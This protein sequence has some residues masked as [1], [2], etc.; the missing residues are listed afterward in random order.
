MMRLLILLALTTA[1][2]QARNSWSWGPDDSSGAGSATT[3]GRSGASVARSSDR[4]GRTSTPS[5]AA[6]FHPSSSAG[7]LAVV[8]P[9]SA[10]AFTAETAAPQ[11]ALLSAAVSAA[12]LVTGEHQR[13]ETRTARKIEGAS[14]GL[15]EG[16]LF[17]IKDK[18]CEVGL[19]FDC[20][21]GY[22]G[23]LSHHDISYVQPVQ[24]VPVGGPIA[25]VP[26]H[27][28][29]G[30][31]HKGYGVPPP[32]YGPPPPIYSPPVYAPPQPIYA[33]PQPSYG[34]P[35]PVYG[36]HKSSYSESVYHEGS[37]LVNHVHT[38][39]HLYDGP[40]VYGKDNHYSGTQT[41]S[42]SSS[43]SFTSFDSLEHGNSFADFSHGGVDK[44]GKPLPVIPPRPGPAI[45]PNIGPSYLEDCQCVDYQY[46]SSFDVVGR[47]QTG[48][49]PF[50]DARSKKTD[51]L[52]TATDEDATTGENQVFS[53]SEGKS[54]VVNAE[55]AEHREKTTERKKR[56][57]VVFKEKP[58]D[59]RDTMVFK[60][61]T[62]TS[63]FSR[64]AAPSRPA[65]ATSRQGLSSYTP[66]P[67]G[68]AP[69]HV[70]CRR[71]GFRQQ[72]EIGSCGRRN[73]VGLLGRVKNDN[74][75]Q[76]DTEFGE[77]PWQAAILRRETGE[78]V[79]VC[80]AALIDRQNLI[81]A[82][83]C[84][85]GLTAGELK[86][87]LGEW[88]VG[89]DTE[90]YRYV[91]SP[92]LALYSHPDF[93]A[94]NLNND[95]AIVRIQTPV[96]FLSNPH[97]SPVCMPE[98][99]ASF[100]GQRCFVSGWGK[101]AFGN[102]GNFQHLLKKVDLPV[103][104]YSTCESALRRTRLGPQFSLHAGMMCAGG[105]EGKDACEGDGGSPLV[106]Q[107]ADGTVQLAGLVSWGVGC[108]QRGVPG[109]YT[110]IPYY[111]E[112]INSVTRR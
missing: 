67:N 34:P 107:G 90:F 31:G 105:E 70:C 94:G 78:S 80:G 35:P 96:D 82:A 95:V 62:R 13:G 69:R 83:H 30:Y 23:G 58:R 39:H 81:T 12:P 87:R 57:T 73:S 33:P 85:T 18:L 109:V 40:N 22:K 2:V 32:A 93:Y 9:P 48:V 37:S 92:V 7:A 3:H 101:D 24:V 100:S 49:H 112:W 28:G 29:K 36:P 4:V 56:D 108:G 50:I 91:E 11:H 68:C 41:H 111:T 64:P 74:I 26:I 38:H 53:A 110:S 65:I 20:K 86:V 52:S 71:P 88:D 6:A 106:C 51:I 102:H 89:G 19:G 42:I 47:A 10:A 25:A 44:V 60:D 14:D 61:N 27:P 45:P 59:A 15:A 55:S 46:C 43:P 79:Y 16:R 17:G 97:I 8:S 99:F 21:K 84:I 72:R 63:T 98:R 1:A 76:G 66:G 104:D 103:V 77:Y 5:D 75:L 54:V